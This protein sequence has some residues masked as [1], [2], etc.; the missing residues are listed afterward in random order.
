MDI[1]YYVKRLQKNFTTNSLYLTVPILQ[2]LLW[3]ITTTYSLYE[4]TYFITIQYD[5]AYNLLLKLTKKR[6]D[7]RPLFLYAKNGIQCTTE[8]YIMNSSKTNA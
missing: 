1:H 3:V 2:F 7:S 5:P 6:E 4:N 8:L